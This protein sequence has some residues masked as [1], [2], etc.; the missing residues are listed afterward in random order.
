[1][2]IYFSKEEMQCHCCD[3]IGEGAEHLAD[4][5]DDVRSKMKIPMKIVSWSRCEKHNKEVGGEDNSAHLRGNAVDIACPNTNYRHVLIG[6]L[7]AAGFKRMGAYK[8][9]WIHADIDETLPQNVF[10]IG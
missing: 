1:M 10:W 2:S 6:M 3:F 9:G 7:Y 4:R 5:L 8:A